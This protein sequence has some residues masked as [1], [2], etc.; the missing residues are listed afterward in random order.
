MGKKNQGSHGQDLFGFYGLQDCT[1][2]NDHAGKR[3]RRTKGGTPK[4]ISLTKNVEAVVGE[5]GPNE[6]LEQLVA[7]QQADSEPSSSEDDPPGK[8]QRVK[9]YG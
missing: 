4:T 9:F 7:E 2:E 1:V 6:I 5:G 3:R 8:P